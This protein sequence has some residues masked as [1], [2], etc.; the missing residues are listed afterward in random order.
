MLRATDGWDQFCDATLAGRDL[1]AA[2]ADKVFVLYF[3]VVKM[4]APFAVFLGYRPLPTLLAYTSQ[5]LRRTSQHRRLLM[6][7]AYSLW[8]R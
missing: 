1:H 7:V 8:P 6:A 2:V 3:A 5:W 4:S